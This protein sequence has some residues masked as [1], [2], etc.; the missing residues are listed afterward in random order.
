MMLSVE[1]IYSGSHV[2]F[3]VSNNG[4]Q[5]LIVSSFS[6]ELMMILFPRS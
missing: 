3:S 6:G 4:L 2:A 1:L 5:K